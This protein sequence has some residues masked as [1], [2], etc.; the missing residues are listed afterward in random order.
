M[1]NLLKRILILKLYRKTGQKSIGFELYC[2]QLKEN[3]KISV[4][5]GRVLWLNKPI[6]IEKRR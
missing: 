5:N 1:G 2:T 6:H 3:L 4:D